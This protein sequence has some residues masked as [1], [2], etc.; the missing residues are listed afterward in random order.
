MA[1]MPPRADRAGWRRRAGAFVRRRGA[2]LM[3]V[4]ALAVGACALAFALHGLG[5]DALLHAI[6]RQPPHQVAASLALT[7]LSF[8]CLAGYDAVGIRLVAHGRVPTRLALLAGATASAI[9]N[10][11]GFH[12]MSGTAVRAHL[13]LPAG[14]RPA[15]LAR[16]V[17]MSW[18]SL[19]AGNATMLAAA[20]L[21]QAAA[22]DRI[23]AHLGVGLALASALV[24]W[25]AWL[26]TDRREVVVRR[27]RMPMPSARLA[28]LLVAI[29][30]VESATAI[31]ALY[32]LL[33]PDLAP[34]FG[35]FAAGCIAVVALGVAA[36]TPGGLGVFEAGMVALLAG[37]GRHDL[38][39]ALLLY[40]LVYNLLPFALALLALG[41]RAALRARRSATTAW[42]NASSRPG[43]AVVTHA[44]DS[45][46]FRTAPARP[47]RTDIPTDQERP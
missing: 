6:A 7:A 4:V 21:A 34:P 11:V 22:A 13:Y 16:V 28:L 39:A 24:L 2:V 8:A 38:L 1:A 41:G 17:S 36:H 3:A 29:G 46:G 15:A 43:H 18:L 40:R 33:P 12:A 37:G 9:A 44:A 14:L 30:A 47:V 27:W 5:L 35:L 23:G 31:G 25:L 32:V 42:P 20:E 10:T 45:R 19:V 26:G